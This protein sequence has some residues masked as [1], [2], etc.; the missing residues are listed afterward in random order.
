MPSMKIENSNVLG[1]EEIKLLATE[2]FKACPDHVDFPLARH[3]YSQA[4]DSDTQAIELHKE[5]QGIRQIVQLHTLDLEEYGN[6]TQMHQGL[7]K[8]P[9]YSRHAL[10]SKT[11]VDLVLLKFHKYYRQLFLSA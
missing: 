10:K 6:A 3:K 11:F 8:D 1:A 9:K 5:T 7:L 4:I 2:A